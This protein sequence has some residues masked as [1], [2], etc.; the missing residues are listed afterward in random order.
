M[1]LGNFEIWNFEILSAAKEEKMCV[2]TNKLRSRY[3]QYTTTYGQYHM[4][5]V[6]INA[7]IRTTYYIYNIPRTCTYITSVFHWG[8]SRGGEIFHYGCGSSF[9]I[10]INVAVSS[11]CVIIRSITACME[12]HHHHLLSH[13]WVRYNRRSSTYFTGNIH[14]LPFCCLTCN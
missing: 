5:Y 8:I 14:L 3:I 6:C 4:Q 7:Y 11:S 12:D 13:E 9:F 1:D 10:I 2:H